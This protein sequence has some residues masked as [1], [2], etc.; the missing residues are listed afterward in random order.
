MSGPQRTWRHSLRL[1][2]AEQSVGF[3]NRVQL[4]IGTPPRYGVA[5]GNQ[6]GICGT[7]VGTAGSGVTTVW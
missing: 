7:G 4:V 5:D 3:W 2:V 1:V 6:V